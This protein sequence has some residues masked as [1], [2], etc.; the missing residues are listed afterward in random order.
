V[1]LIYKI[2]DLYPFKEIRKICSESANMIIS[3]YQY[4]FNTQ[5]I[6]NMYSKIDEALSF[7]VAYS[8]VND[9]YENIEFNTKPINKVFVSGA[10]NKNVYPLRYLIK[11]E[12]IFDQYISKLDH[13]SYGSSSHSTTNKN[14]YIELNKYLCCFT[15]VSAYKF[16]LLKVFEICSVGSL[17]LVEDSIKEQ[18]SLLGFCDNISCIMCNKFN[19]EEKM[20]WILD[21]KNRENVDLI[22]KT[23]MVL[24]K[25]FHN[26]KNRSQ[27]FNKII[28]NIFSK[29]NH[30][31]KYKNDVYFT[32][33]KIQVEYINNG[34][35]EPYSGNIQIV[36]EYLTSTKRNNIYIDV[37]TNIGTHSVVFSK[38]FNKVI[39]FEPDEY[40]FNQTKENININN[41]INVEIYNKALG[42]QIKKVHTKNHSNHSRGCI[43]TSDGGGIECITLDSLNLTNVDYIKIDVEGNELDVLKGAINTITTNFPMIELEYNGLSDKLFNVKYEDIEKFLN[44]LNYFLYKKHESNYFFTKTNNKQIFENIYTKKI[45]NGGNDNIPLSG[46]GSSLQNTKECSIL[47]N[48]FIY[49]NS[50]KSVLDL[51][52]GDLTWMS[53]TNFFNDTKITYNGV[54]VVEFLIEKHKFGFPDKNFYCEDLTIYT[55]FEFASVVIIRDVIFHLKNDEIVKIFKNIKNKFDFIAITSCKNEI[56]NDIFNKFQFSQKNINKEPFNVSDNYIEKLY[57]PAFDRFFYIYTHDNFYK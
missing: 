18:L 38:L 57:E 55:D 7:F 15:D 34:K 32:P 41:I 10:I 1:F 6:K 27:Q 25:N 3:P 16:I 36:E 9:F 42:S 45:W 4:L 19:M 51:G 12:I 56:N 30:Y 33:D 53:K 31:A 8:A 43:Y 37:G 20:K 29:K 54:D 35:A 2:D 17:L 21:E 13:P 46:P 24:V 28:E 11:N 26:T 47:L 52:C 39:S 5:E 48:D 40:N 50:C 23:G 14:Y 44:N 49:K 22:R